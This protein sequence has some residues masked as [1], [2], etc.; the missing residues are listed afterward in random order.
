MSLTIHQI[1]DA[2]ERA[3]VS[4]AG[5]LDGASH[6]ELDRTITELLTLPE[7]STLVLDLGDLVYISSAGLRSVFLARKVMSQRDGRMLVVNPQPQVQK[8]FDIVKAVPLGEIFSSED[9]LDTY[10]ATIQARMLDPDPD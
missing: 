9:E 4:L 2:P 10:L 7:L 6:G 8:V 3:K 1:L 5:E